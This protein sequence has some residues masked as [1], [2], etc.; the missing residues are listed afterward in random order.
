VVALSLAGRPSHT[1]RRNSRKTKSIVG[2]I[3]DPFAPWHVL[4]IQC[5]PDWHSSVEA[6]ETNHHYVNGPDAFMA[7]LLSEYRDAVKRFKN[8]QRKIMQLATPP[9]RSIFDSALRDELLFENDKYTYSRRY[10]WAS[11]TLGLLSNEIKA[12]IVAYQETFTDDFWTGEHK[13]LFPGTKDQSH[14]YSNWRKKMVHTRHLFE[15]E[16]RQLENVYKTF[17]LQQKEIRGLREWLF[18]GT[19][20]LES[21]EAVNQAKITVDQGYNIRLLTLVTLFYLPLTFVTS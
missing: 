6:H 12:M 8:V 18:S 4:S 14:R 16:I 13:T 20:V 7:A 19:S 5:F 3:Y 1:L 9:K 21:R 2:H 17:Q 11:Q 10:F 15:K